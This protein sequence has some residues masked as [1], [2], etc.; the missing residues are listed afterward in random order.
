MEQEDLR[1]IRF[2]NRART[3][4][5]GFVLIAAL[6]LAVLYFALM[7]LL[8]VDSSRELAEA[9][10][11]RARVVAAALVE[12]A[13]EVAAVQMIDGADRT[14]EEKTPQGAMRATLRRGAG[15]SFTIEA[16]AETTGVPGQK[17]K[18]VVYG[19]VEEGVVKIDYSMH[20]Q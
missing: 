6:T 13:V 7:E 10:R 17:A 19:R 8:L 11:F 4:E 20:E 3:S 12:N 15:G 2:F 14:V 9:R 18:I 5:S 1:S 16:D